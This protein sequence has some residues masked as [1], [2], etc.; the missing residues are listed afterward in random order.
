MIGYMVFVPCYDVERWELSVMIESI[1]RMDHVFI[2]RLSTS[3]Y[4]CL[5]LLENW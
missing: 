2:V 4:A 1:L 5:L 3:Q